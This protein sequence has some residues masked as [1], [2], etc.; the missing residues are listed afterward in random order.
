M[1]VSALECDTG[2]GVQQAGYLGAVEVL[3]EPDVSCLE[4]ADAR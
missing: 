2:K 1:A 3:Q 4:I